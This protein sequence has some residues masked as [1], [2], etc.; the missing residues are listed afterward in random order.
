MKNREIIGTLNGLYDLRK[1]EEKREKDEKVFTGRVLFTMSRNLRTL[2][3]EYNE[4]YLKDLQSLREK[5][6]TPKE[7][8]VT[9]PANKEKGTEEHKEKRNV[10]VLKPNCTEQQF[11]EELA[12]LLDIDIK[13]DISKVSPEAVENVYDYRD[14][15]VIQFMVE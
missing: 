10:E 8:E 12:E 14:M 1:R 5:Y 15:D 7:T 11:Q 13:V 3:K 6:Y 9:V 2:E 4:N